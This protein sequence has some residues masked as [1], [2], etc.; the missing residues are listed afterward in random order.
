MSKNPQD[1]LIHILNT[2]SDIA[3]SDEVSK[4]SPARQKI[5][6]G[7]S[8]MI[9]DLCHEIQDQTGIVTFHADDCFGKT[10]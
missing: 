6:H 3:H 5:V 2:L 8:K 4:W 1:E 7:L 10:D 9:I